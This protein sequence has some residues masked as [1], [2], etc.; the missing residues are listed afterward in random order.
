MKKYRLKSGE[1]ITQLITKPDPAAPFIGNFAI[2]ISNMNR[3][4]W[5]YGEESN[6]F[7]ENCVLLHIPHPLPYVEFLITVDKNKLEEVD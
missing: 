3:Y 7:G 4:N 6:D 2:S 1:S 5:L